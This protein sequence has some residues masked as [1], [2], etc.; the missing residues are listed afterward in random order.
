MGLHAIQRHLNKV[1]SDSHLVST[2][3]IGLA[4]Y[5]KYAGVIVIEGNAS[6]YKMTSAHP[7]DGGNAHNFEGDMSL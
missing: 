4:A 7:Q 2:V 5:I 3:S 1:P 6:A